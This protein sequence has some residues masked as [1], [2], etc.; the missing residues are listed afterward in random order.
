MAIPWW[1]SLACSTL[2]PLTFEHG[3]TLLSFLIVADTSNFSNLFK[4]PS[5]QMFHGV[6]NF[7][8]SIVVAM[9]SVAKV[10]QSKPCKPHGSWRKFEEVLRITIINFTKLHI[11]KKCI[12]SIFQCRFHMYKMISLNFFLFLFGLVFMLF[13]NV[14]SPWMINKTYPSW[15]ISVEDTIHWKAERI[16]PK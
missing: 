7:Q 13:G 16:P 8:R 1:F 3:S 2:D 14:F 6:M 4:K 9:M 11:K 10:T 5:T 12:I 15:C